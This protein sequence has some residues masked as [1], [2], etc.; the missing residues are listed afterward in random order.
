MQILFRERRG[1]ERGKR[2]EGESGAVN[3]EDAVEWKWNR[4]DDG[5]G[6]SAR[7]PGALALAGALAA[8]VLFGVLAGPA[9]AKE[10]HVFKDAFGGPGAEAGKLALTE[11]SGIAINGETGDLY[12]ADTGNRRVDE[13]TETGTFVRAFG[14][15][16][17]GPGV[18]VC[19]II[20]VEGTSTAA[21]GG[22]EAPIFIAVDNDNSSASHGDVYVGDSSTNRVTKFDSSGNLIASW[23][24]GVVCPAAP[25]GQLSGSCATPIAG[26]FAEMVGIA[27]DAGGNLDVLVNA[28]PGVEHALYRFSEGGSFIEDFETPRGSTPAGLAV[29]AAGAFFK[30]NGQPNVER[31]SA[32]GS[33]AGQVTNR[34]GASGLAADPSRDD[35]YVD[36]GSSIELYTFNIAGEVVQAGGVT[37][38]PG[39][40]GSGCEP[41]D[42]F[43]SGELTA[44]AGLAVSADHKIYALDSGPQ[45]IDVFARVTLPDVST[46]GA[47]AITETSATVIGTVDPDGVAV[48]ECTF[49]YGISESFGQAAPCLETAGQI[50][51]GTESVAVQANLTGLIPNR[52]YHYRVQ[53]A[54]TDGASSGIDRT[55][56]TPAGVTEPFSPCPN[57]ALR[58]GYGAALPDCRAYEQVSPSDKNGAGLGNTLEQVYATPSGNAISYFAAAGIPV[59]NGSGQQQEPSYVASRAQSGW[60]TEGLN[61]PATDALGSSLVGRSPDL[62]HTF[63]LISNLRGEPFLVDRAS[64]GGTFATIAAAQQPF[65]VGTSSD[66]DT[67]FFES[68]QILAPGAVAGKSNLYAWQQVTGAVTLVGVLPHGEVPPDGVFA[69]SYDWVD[70]TTEQGHSQ[71]A[72][73]LLEAQHAISADG[74]RIVFTAGGSGQI[75]LREDPLGPD[76]STV[77]VSASQK[78]NGSGLGGTD[79]N[80]PQPAAFLGASAD[81]SA[82]FFASCAQ[83]T[84]DSTAISQ[85]PESGCYQPGGGS[86]GATASDLYRYEVG[87]GALTDLTVDHSDPEGAGVQG[88][89]GISEDGSYVYFA[90]NGVLAQNAGPAG[91]HASRGDCAGGVGQQV[92]GASCNVYLY[93]DGT[94]SF[95][96]RLTAGATNGGQRDWNPYPQCSQCN[97]A[98]QNA[99]VSSSGRTLLF[100]AEDSL[101]AY[102]SHGESELYRYAADAGTLTCPSCDPTGAPPTGAASL[103]LEN[104][105]F[106]PP[107]LNPPFL[108]RNLSADGSRVFFNTEQS[109]LPRDVNE[110]QDVYEWELDGTGSCHSAA[111]NGGCLYLIST[112]TSPDDSYFADASAT[113]AN[114]FLFTDQR[115]VGSDQD[116][117]ADL[118]D[119]SSEGG[120]TSQAPAQTATCTG[121]A[122]KPPPAGLPPEATAASVTFSGPGNPTPKRVRKHHRKKHH[123]HH[124]RRGAKKHVHGRGGR[125]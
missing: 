22:F 68:D 106:T 44:G 50:G 90:A 9:F 108:A 31:F 42:A 6:G 105:R 112:G 100:A 113:G 115:L 39:E 95:I 23:G 3:E 71:I 65:M 21:P 120:I 2:D 5:G 49:E 60:S 35:L 32:G 58:Y 83:L 75:Y 24:D 26:P 69:G 81:D 30:V 74:H 123:R 103:R 124:H 118:Y 19:T 8:T 125:R 7:R 84:N 25:D 11:H 41:S 98:Y 57:D 63:D 111:D 54:N 34:E 102:R 121:E 45:R 20:C 99:R 85:S 10:T 62:S 13:F 33:E 92:P 104:A 29:N 56:F 28:A 122:C 46:G 94:T 109:L 36:F 87:S 91:D 51:E 53:A 114:V 80:G 73:Y 48:T 70:G 93:H 86:P 38:V 59:P 97:S 40:A 76:A 15:D 52:I 16:V 88:L 4:V 72:G 107:G 18:D 47:S 119:A 12:V 61:P 27:V 66:G 67:A 37:C 82:T 110:A 116:D 43:G 117:L 89:L 1:S 96:A 55:F 79:P 77:A 17:G 14:T 64:S 78:T 101:T